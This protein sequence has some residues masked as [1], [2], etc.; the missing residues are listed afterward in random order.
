MDVTNAF[1]CQL[2]HAVH[3]CTLH[4]WLSPKSLDRGIERGCGLRWRTAPQHVCHG[5]KRTPPWQPSLPSTWALPEP[6]P[7]AWKNN[8]P[9]NSHYHGEPR[10]V[11]TGKRHWE[12]RNEEKKGTNTPLPL[13]PYRCPQLGSLKG[14]PLTVAEPTHTS[15]QSTLINKQIH[16]NTYT[17]SFPQ[18]YW[19]NTNAH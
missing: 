7:I 9:L 18:T 5:R 17:H 13:Y 16:T 11:G 6:S 1:V 14:L 10:Q 19:T 3:D 12:E 2:S 4:A 15:I 8:P